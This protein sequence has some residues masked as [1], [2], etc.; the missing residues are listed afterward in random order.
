MGDNRRDGGPARPLRC[1]SL[2]EGGACLARQPAVQKRRSARAAAATIRWRAAHLFSTGRIHR[3]RSIG[4]AG[5]RR[6]AVS[7]VPSAEELFQIQRKRGRQDDAGDVERRA[8]ARGKCGESGHP[9]KDC[10]AVKSKRKKSDKMLIDWNVLQPP[11]EKAKEYEAK[12][13]W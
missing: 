11:P 8:A 9:T 7:G 1:P 4:S 6:A 10:P 12:I 13:K 3:G 2:P 5:R